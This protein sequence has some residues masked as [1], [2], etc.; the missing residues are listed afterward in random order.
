MISKEI[1][2]SLCNGKKIRTKDWRGTHNDLPKYICF[3][4]NELVDDKNENFLDKFH[5]DEYHIDLYSIIEYD[6]WEVFDDTKLVSD[7]EED[8]LQKVVVT[9]DIDIDDIL[10]KVSGNQLYIY[11][12]EKP[13][14]SAIIYLPLLDTKFTKLEENKEYTLKDLKIEY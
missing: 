9:L 10:V 2:L 14:N 12:K 8:C 1:L 6:T 5:N 4:E 11:S 13:F 3:N 7:E